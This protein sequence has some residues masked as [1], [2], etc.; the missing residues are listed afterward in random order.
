MDT[1]V[2]IYQIAF[3]SAGNIFIALSV[4]GGPGEETLWNVNY[5]ATLNVCLNSEV[6]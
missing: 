5:V 6:Q 1:H 2:T 4:S 3:V